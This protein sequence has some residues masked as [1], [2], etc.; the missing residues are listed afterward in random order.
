MPRIVPNR[1]CWAAL[2]P[3][4]K[5][6]L[7]FTTLGSSGGSH[8]SGGIHGLLREPHVDSDFRVGLNA[9]WT[10]KVYGSNGSAV[11]TLRVQ[12]L[13]KKALVQFTPK[14]SY[15]SENR[16]ETYAILGYVGPLW[17][18]LRTGW[19]QNCAAPSKCF[20]YACSLREC[21]PTGD[22]TGGTWVRLRCRATVLHGS[23]HRPLF[24]LASFT[25]R[26]IHV[27]MYTHACMYTSIS[28]YTFLDLYI[29]YMRVHVYTY[30]YIYIYVYMFFSLGGPL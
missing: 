7:A 3:L 23:G 27:Y 9:S 25:Y 15:A 11:L 18:R 12:V 30:I 13:E 28:M 6:L 20:F 22:V 21:W 16:S 19:F 14:H 29:D 26:C 8:I 10:L 5:A 2:A 1:H 4:P 17:L 24:R